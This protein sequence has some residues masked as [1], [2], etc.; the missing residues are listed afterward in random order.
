MRDI[1]GSAHGLRSILLASKQCPQPA[2]SALKAIMG[3][4][5]DSGRHHEEKTLQ[6]VHPQTQPLA[7]VPMLVRYTSWLIYDVLCVRVQT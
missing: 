3:D 5:A 2:C 7:A 4:A 1:P 6:S